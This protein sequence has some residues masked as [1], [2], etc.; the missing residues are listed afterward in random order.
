MK[1]NRMNYTQAITKLENNRVKKSEESKN[2]IKDTIEISSESIK[3]NEYLKN[4]KN[5]DSEKI[6]MI[7]QK[8]NEGT[9]RVDTGK[10]ADK[11]LQ[12]IDEQK[13]GE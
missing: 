10:L 5:I 11:I 2:E 9:Y 3:L 4:T 8:L 6:E 1:I 13:D 12:R 7:K